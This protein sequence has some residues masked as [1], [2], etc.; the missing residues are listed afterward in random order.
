MRKD[1]SRLVANVEEKQREVAKRYGHVLFDLAQEKKSVKTVLK[2]GER[3]RRCLR[4]EPLA[5]SHLTSPTIPRQTQGHMVESLAS[6][7]K[8]GRLMRQF[9][10]ILCQNRRLQSLQVIL[11]DFFA[12]EQ[13]ASGMR[14][15]VLE[16]AV[17]LSTRDIEALQKSLKAHMGQDISLRQEVKESLLGGVVLRLGSLMIDASIATQLM[18]LRQVMK[19]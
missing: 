11:D 3:L 5:W 17:E 12:Q 9:L 14:E 8:L 1:D 16:T 2:D 10:I 15:G 19:G 7:L 6:S 4:E 13:A 18:K